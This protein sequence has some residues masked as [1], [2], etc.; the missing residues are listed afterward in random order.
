MK[1]TRFMTYRD[2]KSRYWMAET[3]DG[4]AG[5]EFDERKSHYEA[6]SWFVSHYAGEVYD[7]WRVTKQELYASEVDIW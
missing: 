4:Y 1:S 5:I 6:I 2:E 3:E 7:F